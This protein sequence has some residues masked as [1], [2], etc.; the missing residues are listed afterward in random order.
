MNAIGAFLRQVAGVRRA[1]VV[2][3]LDPAH[4]GTG[5]VR[6]LDPADLVLADEALAARAP[7]RDRLNR[8]LAI[9]LPLST[10]V[11]LVELDG[12]IR[13][14]H[15]LDAVA[16]PLRAADQRLQGALRLAELSRSVARLEHS[17]QVQRALFAISDLAGSD[18]DMPD[19]LRGIHGIV[20]TLMY[21]ENFFIVRYDAARDELRLLYF[22]DV[23]D[24]PPFDVVP[25][26]ALEH[27]LT[28]YVV[29]EGRPLRGDAEQLRSQIS[30]PLRLVGTDSYDWLGVPMR[31]EGTVQGAL[32][33]Q[34]YHPGIVYTAE[35]Q[36]LL[37]FVA[38]HILT[39]LE[40]KRTTE[41]LERDVQLRT[42]E[43]AEANRGLQQEI[44]VRQ[45]AELLQA[46]LFQIAQLAT[47]DIDEDEFYRRIH[48]VVGRLLNARNFFIALL[49]EDR[50]YLEFPYYID[51]HTR[52]NRTDRPL[53]RG[54]SEYVLRH[55]KPLLVPTADIE[56]LVRDGEI[57]IAG[58]GPTA[59]CWLGVPLVFGDE[60]LG[61]VAVQSYDPGVTYGPADQ[62]LLGFVASQIA[63]SLNRRRTAQI[64][65]QAYALLEERV[66][67]RTH[68]LRNEI[69]ERER[70]QD[71][72][73]HE[74]MHDPLTGLPN[75]GRLRDRMERVLARVRHAPDRRC[76]LLYLD[77]DRFKVINDS[78]GHLAGDEV[79]REVARR[80]Q[81]CVREP[82]LVA[83]LSGDEFAVLLENVDVPA[84]AVKV[85]QRLLDVLAAPLEI[86]GKMLEPTASIGIAVGNER[87]QHADELL[88]D[89]DSALYRAKALGRKRYQLFDESL[90][91]SAID[92]LAMEAELREA[93]HADLFEPHFQPI[94]RLADAVVVGHEAL[95][96]WNHPVR[97]VLGPAYFLQVAEENGIIEAIDWRMF[98]LSCERAARLPGGHYLTINVAPRH[99]RRE[100]F[101]TRLIDT[102]RDAGLPPARLLIEVTEGSLLDDPE[103]V[104]AILGRL[105]TV[106]IGAALDD[107]GTG[108]SSLSYLHTFPLR[109]LKVDRAFVSEL[110]KPG[111]DNSASVIAAVLALARALG[112]GVVAEGIE[113]HAQREAL[114]A[115]GCEFGQGHLFGR[116]APIDYWLETTAP[117]DVGVG[118][119]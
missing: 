105:Q 55:G 15:V 18:H 49:S 83:R 82:D 91:R 106:G 102:A 116:P 95:L 34:S 22:A 90:Q 63:N 104:R 46:A 24:Q 32:V 71:Q 17:E 117:R 44:V 54:L 98:A 73:Q 58:Q 50:R 69:R 64:Q 57:E 67:E 119:V 1:R 86:A 36:T 38:S 5:M 26:S 80:L 8:R 75:R 111:K 81:S 108:Y 88:R 35:D 101:D 109:M 37:E 97:G 66:E 3:E 107:F 84:T 114:I 87:Y 78:L 62:E 14:E 42:L 41:D 33:V 51:T 25:M 12:R 74:V 103:R 19:L 60:A 70:V 16:E 29:H 99:F 52:K 20:G 59:V 94:V 79:L 96:R 6:S 10:A 45:R 115:L 110:G 89:A 21:A 118:I 53:A 85:A 92:V 112:M 39:A 113:T 43:L 9:P 77:V 65:Q 27:S 68:E 7:Q 30:G 93:L 2:W 13:A 100:D 48:E 47:E 31:R 40:R 61:L 11:V 23:Y 72:L 28:W 76:A 56:A 4:A